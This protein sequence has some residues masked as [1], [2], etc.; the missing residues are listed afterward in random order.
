MVGTVQLEL[1]T[2]PNA[3][4]R[5]EVQKLMVLQSQR[6][7]GI[8]KLLMEAIEGVA[9][10]HNRMLLVLDTRQGDTAEQLYRKIGYVEA[11]IIPSYARNAA[12]S[13]DA[14]VLFYKLLT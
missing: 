9:Q 14:T 3:R 6:G 8:G 13:L 7:Q 10:E 5:A 4:H 2:K 11:G 12:G 1:A